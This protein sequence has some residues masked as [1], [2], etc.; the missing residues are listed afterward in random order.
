MCRPL[1][2]SGKLIAVSLMVNP[3]PRPA[4][5]SVADRLYSGSQD[6]PGF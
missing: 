3:E 1:A 5:T 4:L 6:A 2:V